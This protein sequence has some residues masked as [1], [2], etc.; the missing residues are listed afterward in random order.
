V[1]NNSRPYRATITGPLRTTHYDYPSKEERG[2]WSHTP[3]KFT[4]VTSRKPVKRGEPVCWVN[5]YPNGPVAYMTVADANDAASDIYGRSRL[6]C[7]PV[8]LPGEGAEPVT[9][10]MREAAVGY[11][12]QG[13]K[14]RQRIG[15]LE[16]EVERLKGVLDAERG[17]LLGCN[18]TLLEGRNHAQAEVERLTKQV[19]AL[20][21]LRATE[22]N[23]LSDAYVRQVDA[24]KAERDI[25]KA[26]AFGSSRN[27]VPS[28]DR[29]EPSMGY[30]PGNVEWIC[31]ECNRR[32]DDMSY[33]KMLEFAKRGLE[34]NGK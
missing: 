21:D 24:L 34:R 6:H 20:K 23:V 16:S 12:M 1:S 28:L 13:V 19:Q 3:A 7:I 30:V 17:R 25:A 15:E 14:D 22:N 33:A 29:L 27:N 2:S 5:V 8:Y 9:E 11:Y 26:D 10:Q 4:T 18:E 32:K 31:M